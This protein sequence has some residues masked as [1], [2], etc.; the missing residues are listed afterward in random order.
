MGRAR[1]RGGR[2]PRGGRVRWPADPA[3]ST[4]SVGRWGGAWC[5]VGGGPC[6]PAEPEACVLYCH[7]LVGPGGVAFGFVKLDGHV[8]LLREARSDGSVRL[9]RV[10]DVAAGVTAGTGDPGPGG[11]GRSRRRERRRDERGGDPRPG[12]GA[13]ARGRCPPSGRPTRWS[14]GSAQRRRAL[15]AAPVLEIASEVTGVEPAELPRADESSLGADLELTASGS[16]GLRLGAEARAGCRRGSAPPGTARGR[17]GDLRPRAGGSLDVQRAFFG[18]HAEGAAGAAVTVSFD[19]EG[20][21]TE[22]EVAAVADGRRPGRPPGGHAA[23]RGRPGRARGPDRGLRDARP[24]RLRTTARAASGCSPRSRRRAG[25]LPG[26]AARSLGG[27]PPRARERGAAAR[28]RGSAYARGPADGRAAVGGV[29]GRSPD[30]VR[31]SRD[32]WRPPGGVW[33]RRVECG[34]DRA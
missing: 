19:R 6:R 7:G 23:R 11:A 33:D 15:I 26:A 24:D 25:E 9:T 21:A 34:G 30:D 8:G 29:S 32:W 20:R 4:Q 5:R 28:R 18:L 13:G 31:G 16:A 10:D 17:P 22:L 27:W 1:C 3:S 2:R 14:A 12:S